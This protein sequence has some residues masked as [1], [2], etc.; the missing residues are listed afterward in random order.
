MLLVGTLNKM[1]EY[2]SGIHAVL[3]FEFSRALR[4]TELLIVSGYSFGDKGINRQ[5]AEW[6]NSSDQ[7]QKVMVVIHSEP[8]D[9]KKGAGTD[10]FMDWDRWLQSKRLVLVPR[11]IQDTSWKDIKDAIQI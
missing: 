2:T 6:V 9:L 3:F 8:K 10:I 4:E 5:L 7:K 1:L 11:W